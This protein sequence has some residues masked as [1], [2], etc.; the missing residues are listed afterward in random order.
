MLR[1]GMPYG[2]R[3][4]FWALLGPDIT[5]RPTEYDA[6]AAAETFRLPH[7]IIPDWPN[8]SKRT[9]WRCP[10]AEALAVFSRWVRRSDDAPG[11]E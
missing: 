1:I 10:D 3:S 2:S 8:S 4:A 6:N 7:R 5:L 11:A 9:C